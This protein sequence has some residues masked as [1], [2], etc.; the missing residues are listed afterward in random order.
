MTSYFSQLFL[1]IQ[2]R[3]KEQMPDGIKW[4][5]QDFGQDVYDKW[6]PNVAFPA[7]LVDFV[8]ADYENISGGGQTAEVTVSL[9]LLVAPFE[10]SYEAAPIEVRKG[11]LEYFDLEQ[12][13]VDAFNGW[14]PNY[15]DEDSGETVYYSQAF[16]RKRITSNNRNDIGLRIRELQFTTYY[17]EQ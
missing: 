9:R 2:A 6:R 7:V 4:I 14:E 5:E 16:V 1:D 11:A 15:V 13:L 10:Q 17:D 3:I 12:Q 8:S